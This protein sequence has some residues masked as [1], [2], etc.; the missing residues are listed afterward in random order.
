VSVHASATTCESS[1]VGLSQRPSR[2]TL[3]CLTLLCRTRVCA[4]AGYHPVFGAASTYLVLDARLQAEQLARGAGPDAHGAAHAGQLLGAAA[5]GRLLRRLSLCM[6][7]TYEWAAAPKHLLIASSARYLCQEVVSWADCMSLH[8]TERQCH[9]DAR[10]VTC[11]HEGQ[12]NDVK[13][14]A[15]AALVAAAAAAAAASAA[16]LLSF[17]LRRGPMMAENSAAPAA[18]TPTFS[19]CSKQ[20]CD[21]TKGRVA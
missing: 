3:W 1:S 10:Q 9:P 15:P 21:W 11:C 5:G 16:A 19:S 4:A 12:D 17:A 7:R 20:S 14:T 6:F 8:A 18:G 13:T 2:F